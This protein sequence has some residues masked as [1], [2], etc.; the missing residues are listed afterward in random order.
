MFPGPLPVFLQSCQ[1][2]DLALLLRSN[3]RASSCIEFGA[4]QVII[5]Q[6]E[7]A[8]K[9][10]P[11]VLKGAI[12]LTVFESKGLEFDDVLLYNFFTDS[13]VSEW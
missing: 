4:H 10:L 7:E 2:T 9:C 6:S 3:K 11:E 5:V 1:V 12:V 8:K 13:T